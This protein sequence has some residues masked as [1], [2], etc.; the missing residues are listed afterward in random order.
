MEIACAEDQ[1]KRLWVHPIN[2][3]RKKENTLRNFNNEVRSD[4][5]L[6]V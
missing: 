1:D 2:K 5:T 6:N 3:K 4:D